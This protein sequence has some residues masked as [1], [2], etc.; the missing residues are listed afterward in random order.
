MLCK[1]AHWNYNEAEVIVTIANRRNA[2]VAGAKSMSIRSWSELC[3][4]TLQISES[5]YDSTDVS[6]TPINGATAGKAA[7]M[8]QSH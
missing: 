2:T 7:R 6:P 1:C 3:V 8:A 5:V 4:V